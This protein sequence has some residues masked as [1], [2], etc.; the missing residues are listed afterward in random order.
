M[1]WSWHRD[2]EDLKLVKAFIYLSDVD[3]QCGPFTY[4]PKTHPFGARNVK[5]ARL[6]KN[7][8]VE[9]SR[10]SGT[11]PP[12]AWRVCT[13]PANTMILADTVG[14]HRGGKPLAGRRILITFSYTSGIPIE[15]SG[16]WLQRMPAWISS[17]IQKA[18]VTWLLEPVRRRKKK[19]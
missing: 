10:M 7:T 1:P 15:D 16:L 4:V 14:Y 5:A 12:E 19:R 8:R 6:E 18:A 11:F 17:G 13:G 2:P 3:E 9:E